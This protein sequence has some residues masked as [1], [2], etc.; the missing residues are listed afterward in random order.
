MLGLSL[1]SVG[2]L[3]PLGSL[4]KP[5]TLVPPGSLPS[6]G[7]LLSQ[8]SLFLLGTLR[9]VGSLVLRGALFLSGSL[10]V[11]GAL[12]SWGSLHRLGALFREGSLFNSGALAPPG[13]PL[14]DTIGPI[15]WTGVHFSAGC[16]VANASPGLCLRPCT[17]ACALPP[18]PRLSGLARIIWRALGQYVP[19]LGVPR[20]RG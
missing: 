6:K 19:S 1:R 4:L 11:S 10:S 14:R 7:T 5:G 17:C 9:G 16:R 8:G 20:F 12:L 15:P 18:D 13:F 3:M 2:T